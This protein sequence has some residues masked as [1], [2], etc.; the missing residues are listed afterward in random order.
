MKKLLTIAILVTS[1]LF[2][3]SC[4]DDDDPSLAELSVTN[5]TSP[6]QAQVGTTITVD[7]SYTAEAGF[8]SSAVSATGGTATITVDGTANATEG[9]ITVTYIAGTDVGAGSIVLDVTDN[10]SS[11]DEGV[12]VINVTVEAVI[13]PATEVDVFASNEGVIPNPSS[14]FTEGDAQSVTWT[15]DNIYILR[16][17]VFVNAGETLTIEP[18]TVIKGQPGQGAGASALIIARGGKIDAVGTASLPIVFTALSDELDPADIAAGNYSS[19]NLTADDSGLW[20]GLIILGNATIAA[21]NTE[22][23]IEGIPTSES[24]GLY[25][26]TDDEDDSGDIAYVS[27]RHAG[28]N[29]GAGNEI[30]GITFGGV[31]SGTSVSWIEVVANADDGIEWFG[32]TVDVTNVVVWNVGDD[33]LDTDQDWVGTCSG[34]LVVTPSGSAF[35]L[36]GP[37]PSGATSKAPHSFTDGTIYAGDNIDHLVDWDGSTNAGLRNLYFLGWSTDYGFLE[38]EDPDE[39]GNQNFNPIEDFGGDGSG[40]TNSWEYTL[41]SGGADAAEIFAGVNAGVAR[42]VAAGTN[43]VGGPPSSNFD[44]TFAGHSGALP[45]LGL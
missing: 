40:T 36:D 28:T 20:G 21:S 38:D 26:G 2:L 5:T 44:W 24:R 16:G 27:V 17:F 43:T 37:E 8:A 10:N 12:A 35:E 22:V 45:G 6:V 19:P 25:G 23:Q 42:E 13:T 39:P 11:S 7:F 32:G 34:F 30:N 15:S 4:G 31:G 14:D 41:T 29:I 3:I 1:M 33:G 9:I 18:G